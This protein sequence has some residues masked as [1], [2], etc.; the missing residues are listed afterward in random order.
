MPSDVLPSDKQLSPRFDEALAYSSKLHRSQPR[1][2]TPIPYVSHLL[3]VASLVI[4]Y[5]GTETEAIA[6]LLHDAVEDQGGVERRAEIA[7]RFG[8]D[9]AVIVDG[10]TDAVE[11]PKPAW[12]ERKKKY[13]AH[14][15]TASPS[16]KLVSAADKLYNARAILRDYRR[17]GDE[18]WSRFSAKKPQI[19]WYY[20]SLVDALGAGA[21]AR[22]AELVGELD[23]VVKELV[24]LAG[25]PASRT[26]I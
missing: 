19:F 6:A 17:I 22:G 16:V 7:R 24:A 20:T 12:E 25:A 15:R 2:G 4:E 1:K 26:T 10:C 8:E 3:G 11:N 5:G 14:A 21:D 13:V 9:V 23:R 18:V